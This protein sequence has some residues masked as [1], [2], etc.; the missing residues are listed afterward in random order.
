M[1]TVA[2][3]GS[4]DTLQPD[5]IQ[6]WRDAIGLNVLIPDD[7]TPHHSGFR[8]PDDLLARSPL[9]RWQDQPTLDR[10]RKINGLAANASPVFPGV[11]GPRYDDSRLLRLI[12]VADRLGVEVWGHLGLWG[13]GGDVF[14]ELALQDDQGQGVP[15]EFI[16][17]GVPICPCNTEVRDWTAECLQHIARAYGFKGIDVDHGHFPPPASIAALTGCCCPR[18][19][20]RARQLGYDFEAFKAALRRLRERGSRLTLS[21][22]TR[23]AELSYGFTDVLS[24]LGYDSVLLDWFRFRSQVVTE[25]MAALT[26][27]VHTAVGDACTVDSHLFPPSIAFLSG[28]DLPAWESAVDRLTP[29]WGPVVGWELAQTNTFAVWARRLCASVQGLDESLAL[30]V[31]YRLFGYD[32]LAMPKSIAELE[33]ERFPVVDVLALEIRKAIG[34]FSGQKPFLAPYRTWGITPDQVARLGEVIREYS[35]AG[36]V[37][38][39][40]PSDETLRAM[41]SAL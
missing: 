40:K 15:E 28:Q 9:A 29:G 32:H 25:H 18:C 20:T 7:Y 33:D 8:L 1:K 11:V 2:W 36:F 19:Q 34:V 35:P 21:D 16:R 38:G 6:R 12:E 37:T 14:P 23:A 31:L 10:H 39:L 13:Y 17:W 5:S 26:R 3:F 24:R 4:I 27:A 30:G 22:F 41:R